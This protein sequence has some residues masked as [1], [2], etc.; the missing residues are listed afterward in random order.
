[1][2]IVKPA[3]EL[4]S[5][6]CRWYV[7][8]SSWVTLLLAPPFWFVVQFVCPRGAVEDGAGAGAG[9]PLGAGRDDAEGPGSVLGDVL[10]ISAEDA[11]GLRFGDGLDGDEDA[12]GSGLGDDAGPDCA[13]QWSRIEL[14]GH[15]GTLTDMPVSFPD[16]RQA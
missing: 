15:S 16:P 2:Q 13:T 10:G 3:P 5:F 6:A 8:S 1:V 4:Y 12:L 14:A 11:R 7:S 9:G